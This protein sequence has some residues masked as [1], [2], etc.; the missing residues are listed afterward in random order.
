MR[1]VASILSMLF[2][3]ACSRAG[4]V[5][6]SPTAAVDPWCHR[7]SQGEIESTKLSP[8]PA[9]KFERV[10]ESR[11]A[12][13]EDALAKRAW[14]RVTLDEA[15]E[16][17]GRRLSADGGEVAVLLRGVETKKKSDDSYVADQLDLQ[18]GG[19]VVVV[20]SRCWRAWPMPPA[21]H[22]PVVAILPREPTDV[23]IEQLVAFTGGVE[24]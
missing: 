11:L 2:L 9:G 18:W 12:D 13:A 3:V 10:V 14:K 4:E 5:P 22:S 7:R 6:A 1:K 15:Q 17:V 20:R 24:K 8:V 19:G 21:R 23:F 16:L